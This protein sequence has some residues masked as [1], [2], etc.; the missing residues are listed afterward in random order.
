MDVML[1]LGLTWGDMDCFHWDNV[2]GTG[3][4]YHFSVETS[5]PPDTSYQKKSQPTNCRPMT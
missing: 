2:S 5:T 1:C 4:D 3:D